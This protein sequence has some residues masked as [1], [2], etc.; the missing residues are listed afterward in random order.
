MAV[1]LQHGL[2][3]QAAAARLER[4]GYN[5][6]SSAQPHS[7]FFIALNV[8][9][10]PMFL[11]L[12]AC[13][14]VYLLLGN[15]AEAL[16]LL[17]F[18]FVII[19][20]SFF[21]MRKTERALEALRDLSS[22]RALVIRDSRQKRIPGREVVR[23][24]LLLLAEGDR[25]PAD[26]VLLS[27]ISL[28]VDESLLTGEAVPVR[29]MPVDTLPGRMGQPGGDDL[30]FLYSGTLLVQGKGVAMVMA[31]GQNTALGAIGR[32]LE[33]VRQ[34]PTN[35]QRETA[36]IVRRAAWTGLA[37]SL[38]A[39]VVY[40]LT[41][42]DWLNG[43]LAGITFAMAVLPEEL[44][45]VMTAFLGLGAW[46]IAQKQV[47]T[48]HVPAIEMLGA[49]TVL[50]VDKTGT[51]TQNR[52][53]MA[54]LYGQGRTLDLAAL[55]GST[56]PEDFHALLEFATL[57]SHRDPFDP[58]E[59]AIN[60]ATQQTLAGTEHVHQDWVLVD[61]YP[62]SRDLLAMSRVWRSPDHEHFV[63]AAKGAP[64]A[65]FDLCH[66]DPVQT[67]ALTG[68]VRQLA[69]QGLRVL[70]VARAAF[71]QAA[72]P[73]IQHDFEFEFLGLLGLIDP[74]REEVPAAIRESHAAG[75]R[76]IMITGDYPATALNIASQV[77]IATDGVITGTQ[78]DAMSD[79]EL[80]RRVKAVAVFCRTV[81]EQKL[82]LVNALKANGEIVAM[83]GDGVNDAPALKAAHIGIA[84]GARGTDVAR[85]AA[86]LV[87]LNDDFASIV[88]AI[89]AG[90]RIFDNLKKA[91]TFIIGVHLPIIGMTLIPVALGWPLLLLPVHI[92]FLQL[93]IDPACS[94]VFEAEPDEQDSMRRPPRSPSA[95]LFDQHTLRLGLLQGMV[96]LAVLL[97][98][99]AAA[100]HYGRAD[101]VARAL[102]FSAMIV[103]SLGLIF[104]NRSHS[105]SL[106]ATLGTR[107]RALRWVMG[108]ALLLLGLVLYMPALRGLFYFG[109]VRAGDLAIVVGAGAGCI[110]VLE[111]VRR[112]A[113][114]PL[115]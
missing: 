64:E 46:R 112:H 18:V 34:E 90:R 3:H 76:V 74:I 108:G 43:L 95:R 47:L 38:A 25:V 31:T 48:R 8:V 7:L 30:P 69:E 16:M 107:N 14:S 13:G 81:P 42:G 102:T 99:Y 28:S 71:R 75:I 32:A 40:G 53:T 45:V 20:I 79:A 5:Q 50:C 100:L 49:A 23:G 17:G 62:L 89:R 57:A 73:E 44:P 115:K 111:L 78:L 39:A 110:V 91:I 86:D 12:I 26:A 56:L 113:L 82:R 85:E 93:I 33:G 88:A 94:I 84:M 19:A 15:R 65:I 109:A 36:V 11:L 105:R 60:Q 106:W 72:L 24:D 35:I 98:I 21:Q 96:L 41:R 83:T 27:G 52:M 1:D 6:L 54:I 70:G 103:A 58:M 68:E 22:P 59:Q 63:I 4:D 66:L 104:A 37:L 97:V 55:A 67:A 10:E 29:K 101:G 77:G 2:T 9:R 87:L 51:L 61:E 114:T 80:R 92:L